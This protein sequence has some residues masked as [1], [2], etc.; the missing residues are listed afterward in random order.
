MKMMN[1]FYFLGTVYATE[2]LI[3]NLDEIGVYSAN[4]E[5]PEHIYN[6]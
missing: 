1:W 5:C 2:A 3:M 6:Q 4:L